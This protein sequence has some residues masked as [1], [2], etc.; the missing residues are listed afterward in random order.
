MSASIAVDLVATGRNIDARRKE[1]EVT[2][3]ERAELLYCTPQAVSKWI[4]GR[5][6]PS[7]D[8]LVL[9]ADYFHCGIDDIIVRNHK[10]GSG[11]PHE[12]NHKEEGGDNPS[13]PA[14]NIFGRIYVY[15]R[16]IF[17]RRR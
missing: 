9:L 5:C 13:S 2:I 16:S 17:M 4:N 7:L 11:G 10:P 1:R 15:A 6:A 12:N 3:Q 8:S 14:T